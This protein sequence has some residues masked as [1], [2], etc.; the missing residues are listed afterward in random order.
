[1]DWRRAVRWYCFKAKRAAKRVAGYREDQWGRVVYI[2]EWRAFL[3][4]LPLRSMSALE[5]SPGTVSHWRNMGFGSYEA[6]SYPDFD[7]TKQALPR[8]FD[9]IIAEHVFEHLRDPTTLP[10]TFMI[11]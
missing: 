1:M 8:T 6:V 9:I 3:S 5:I 10:Q 11:C 2:D 7:I 4:E